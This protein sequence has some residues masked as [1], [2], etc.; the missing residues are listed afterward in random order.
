MKFR[1]KV[2]AIV[3]KIPK[4]KSMTYKEVAR[5]A[6]NAK[7]ARAVGAT[8]SSVPTALWAVIIVAAH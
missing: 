8:A 7:A 3:R 1:D 4:G 6:G 5:K 2:L